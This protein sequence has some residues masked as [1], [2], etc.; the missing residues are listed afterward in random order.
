L[1]ELGVLYARDEEGEDPTLLVENYYRQRA[2]EL[3]FKGERLEASVMQKI[4]DFN[5]KADIDQAEEILEIKKK[6]GLKKDV[7]SIDEWKQELD[8]T[9][10]KE[11]MEQARYIKRQYNQLDE[12]LTHCVEKKVKIN[13]VVMTEKR[14]EEAL[15]FAK[16][17]PMMLD[18]TF[19]VLA[20]PAEDGVQDYYMPDVVKKI[21][22]V[23]YTDEIMENFN[24]SVA[25][26][27]TQNL[28]ERAK[29]AEQ[30]RIAK[31]KQEFVNKTQDGYLAALEDM[32]KKEGRAV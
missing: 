32:R 17:S 21:V 24:K 27:R 4:N 2:E 23:K 10:S 6:L 19:V 22:A 26:A 3:G 16:D 9:Y 30:Q 31:E 25:S 29:E 1:K 28:T 8:S 12:Y 20:D 7:K 5:S 14:K 15:Q 11:L 18:P 13:G